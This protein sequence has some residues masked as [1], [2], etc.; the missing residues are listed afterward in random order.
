MIWGLQGL[1]LFAFQFVIGAPSQHEGITE[2][3]SI[4]IEVSSHHDGPMYAILS[5]IVLPL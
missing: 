3:C 2:T 4:V 5:T 1:G